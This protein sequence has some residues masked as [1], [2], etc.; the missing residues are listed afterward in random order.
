[1]ALRLIYA[2]SVKPVTVA[3]IAAQVRADLTLET[4][5][6]EAYIAAVVEKAEAY[7][8]RALISQTWEMVLDC[9]PDREI[10]LPLAPL[11]SVTSIKYLDG[12][13]VLQTIDSSGYSV[14]TAS[15]PGRVVPA[16][17]TS[18]PGT[19]DM[20]GAVVVR[21]VCGYGPAAADVP[22]SIKA[23]IML[24]VSSLYENRDTVIIGNIVNELNTMAD[25]LINTY[26][27]VSW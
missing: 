26:R 6:V 3:D 21:Y 4:T 24:N 11:L 13:G 16:Y 17:G 18:W 12:A 20:P 22:A 14:D 23:W 19:Q 5:L 15:T 25:S 27:V 9:F 10:L 7:T 8:R 2:P 1:M